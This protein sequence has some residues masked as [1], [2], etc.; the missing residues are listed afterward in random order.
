MAD[1]KNNYENGKIYTIRSPQTDKYYIGSTCNPLYKRLGQ[2]KIDYKKYIAGTCHNITSFEIIKLGDA[3]IELLEN[4]KCNSKDELN[5]REGELIR[6]HNDN[7]VNR[8]IAGR[9]YKEYLE[10]NKER[11]KERDKKYRED[12]KDE[13]KERK[14]KNYNNKKNKIKKKK[15][16]KK[17]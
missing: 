14:K 15:K 4:F 9:T 6:L 16:K 8:C 5:K 7:V 10:D 1:K 13:I 2:H 11:I 12:N 3:Y 17:K